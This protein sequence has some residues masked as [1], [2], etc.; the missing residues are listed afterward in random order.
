MT[1]VEFIDL[2]SYCPINLT[3]LEAF[4]RFYGV[5]FSEEA[6]GYFCALPDGEF[7]STESERFAHVLDSDS[8]LLSEEQIC[9]D[10]ASNNLLPLIDISDG[11][12]VCY[13][14]KDQTWGCYA[15]ADKCLFCI[16]PSLTEVLSA[17]EL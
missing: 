12:Y 9:H 7:L 17:L 15:I 1:I 14:G 13:I 6:E 8:I 10:F 2:A 5:T 11:V 16:Y 4:E 3:K